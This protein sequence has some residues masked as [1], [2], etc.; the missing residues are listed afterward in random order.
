MIAPLL[1]KSSSTTRH[2]QEHGI[3]SLMP[4][5]GIRDF[6]LLANTGPPI[7]NARPLPRP[8]ARLSGPGYA[9]LQREFEAALARYGRLPDG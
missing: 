7:P 8:H 9:W 4:E 2:N 3:K 5:L 6:F 1:E